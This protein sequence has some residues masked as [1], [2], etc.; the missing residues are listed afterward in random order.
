[1]TSLLSA[2]LGWAVG[3]RSATPPTVLARAL[4]HGRRPRRQPARALASAAS[5]LPLAA[6]GEILADKLPAMPNRTAPPVLA[7]RIAV[8]ALVGAV[9]GQIRRTSPVA[10]GLAGAAGAA[11]SSFAM[12]RLRGWVG[13]TLDLPDPAVAVAEDALTIGLSTAVVRRA[14][15]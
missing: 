6:G 2:A 13:E 14:L 12:M 10:A 8:G 9:L 7:E 4:A 1:M 15:R 3:M 5:W 11:A